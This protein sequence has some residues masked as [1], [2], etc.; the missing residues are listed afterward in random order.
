MKNKFRIGDLFTV[1]TGKDLIYSTLLEGKYNV[2]GHG[3]E[4]NGITATTDFLSN[5]KLY[6]PDKT[7]ALANRGNFYASVQTKE[8]YV[9]TRVKALTARFNSNKYILM[10]IATI[11][12]QEQFRYSYGRNACD[13]IEDIIIE[14]P[15]QNG[16]PDYKFMEDYMKKKYNRSVVETKN[17]VK[18]IM[19]V[20]QK[21]KIFKVSD[22]FNC[23][24]AKALDINVAV[25]G[26]IPYITRSALNNGF[27]GRYGNYEII[28]KGN[29]I[30]I[31]AEGRTAFYQSKDFISGV[32]V[33]TLRNKMLNKY[34]A[35]F[36]ITILNKK[37][38]LYNYGRARILEKIVN[39]EICLP[40]D[41]CNNVDWVFMEDYIKSLPYG[42]VI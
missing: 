27:S 10:Y 12:N 26:N 2:I 15:S 36:I 16:I 28:T 4:N 35:M 13:K 42:D 7:I 39:E 37:I 25:E 1:E 24:T 18:P 5:Y 9:G 31:G 22:I 20:E 6:Y 3:V 14:L 30:T 32:K 40:V 11:I 41:N 8:F 38:E 21:W 19:P 34:N 33:Y 17:K 23:T 29:C